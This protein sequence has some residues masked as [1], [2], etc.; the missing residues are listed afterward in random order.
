MKTPDFLKF[1]ETH[2]D[3]QVAEW[4]GCASRSVASW[5]RLERRPRLR[6]AVKLIA[7]SRGELTMDAI[8]AVPLRQVRR[9]YQRRDAA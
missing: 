3:E 6:Y 2:G 7:V 4:A 5:R 9:P 1:L 8:Y